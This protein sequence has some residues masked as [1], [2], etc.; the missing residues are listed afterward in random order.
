MTIHCAIDH[1]ATAH[2]EADYV[3]NRESGMECKAQNPTSSAA[4]VY[5]IVEGTWASWWSTLHSRFAGWGL[6]DNRLLWRSHV[7]VAILAAHRWGWS[8]WGG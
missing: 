8:P 4:G 7:L 2:A 6:R 1:F 3:A 5:Q